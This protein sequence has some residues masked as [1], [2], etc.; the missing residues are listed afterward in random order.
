MAVCLDYQT[1]YLRRESSS[2]GWHLCVASGVILIGTLMGQI[3][4][5]TE[6]TDLGYQIAEQHR[7]QGQLTMERQELELERIVLHRPDQLKE[8]AAKKLGFRSPQKDQVFRV[9]R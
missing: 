8:R 1:V 2:L 7:L 6:V 5:R 4:V 3:W 9:E